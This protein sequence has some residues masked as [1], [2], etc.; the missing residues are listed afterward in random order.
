VGGGERPGNSLL[1]HVELVKLGAMDKKQKMKGERRIL[2]RKKDR[3]LPK[4]QAKN[5][6][7]RKMEDRSSDFTKRGPLPDH[8]GLVRHGR[9]GKD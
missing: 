7:V 8:G 1:I 4:N 6:N 9:S 5:K 2:V 3:S